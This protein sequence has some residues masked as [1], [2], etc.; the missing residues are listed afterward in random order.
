MK[1]QI[2]ASMSA[3]LCLAASGS[4]FADAKGD[5]IAKAYYGLSKAADTKAAATM[6][7]VDK[8]GAKKVRKLEIDYRETAEGKDAYLVFSEPA[9]VAGTKFLTIAHKGAES[10]QRLYLPALKKTRKISS[11]GKDGAF[12]NSDFWFYDLEDRRFEDNAYAFLAAGATIADKAFDGMKF[13]KVEM[14]PTDANAPYAKCV[15]YANQA[16]HFIY[17]L[18]CYD[19]KDGALL[20]TFLFVKVES[21]K[22]HLIPTQTMVTNNKTGSKTLL[23]MS[24]LKVDVGANAELFSEKNLEK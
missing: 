23:A 7:I 3:A 5:E 22:G 1:R 20:K 16:D 14:K 4:A 2:I 8:T 10:E 6:T 13:D 21:V 11:S 19:K 18:E 9:D 12:V 15:A 17:K 24:D